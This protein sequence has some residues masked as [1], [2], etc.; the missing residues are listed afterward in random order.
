VR[1]REFITLLG[2][3]AAAW[4]L[5]AVA[6]RPTIPIIGFLS[7]GSQQSDVWRVAAFRGGLS[8]TGYIEGHNVVGEFRWAHDQYDRLPAL[9]VELARSQPAVMVAVGGPALLSLP[10]RQA[11]HSRRLRHCR[12]PREAWP[13]REHQSTGGNATG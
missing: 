10:R 1:R 6:Q 3:A 12:R 11:Q 7:S 9:A 2:G 5:A 8:E 4:P 13:R